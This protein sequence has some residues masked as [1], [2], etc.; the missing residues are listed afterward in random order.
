LVVQQYYIRDVFSEALLI[1]SDSE[2]AKR[3]WRG[4]QTKANKSAIVDF[5]KAFLSEDPLTFQQLFNYALYLFDN[6][7]GHFNNYGNDYVLGVTQMSQKVHREKHRMEAFVR[8]QKSGSSLYYATV[9]PDFN[10]LPLIV[11]HFKNRYADQTWVIYDER[12]KYGIFH[13]LNGSLHEVTFEFKPLTAA[14]DQSLT[15]VTV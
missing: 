9:S 2:K 3:V 1:C 7:K 10:V 4:L 13:D 8:F 6:P 11:P 5:Y 15:T 14:P 12:R